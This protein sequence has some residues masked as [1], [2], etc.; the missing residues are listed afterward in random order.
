MTALSAFLLPEAAT[1]LTIISQSAAWT[2][3]RT[4]NGNSSATPLLHVHDGFESRLSNVRLI[5]V[6]GTALAVRRANTKWYDVF[7]HHCGTGNAAAVVIK[8]PTA[9]EGGGTNT[10]DVYNLT[11]ERS[12]N[13]ALDIAYGD[14]R[15]NGAYAELVRITNAHIE[16]ADDLGG[17]CNS[18]PLIR[19]GNVRGATFVNPFLYGRPG[20]LIGRAARHT[21]PPSWPR[22]CSSSAATC[23]G[24]RTTAPSAWCT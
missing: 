3:R 8:S 21:T 4:W 12:A 18:A 17:V 22:A 24:R 20:Y 1:P 9:A 23:S 2:G 19:I 13:V 10:L 11:L 6:A 15:A 5:G 14:A 7:V 16:A